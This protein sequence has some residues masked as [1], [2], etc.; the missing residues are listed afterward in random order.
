MAASMLQFDFMLNLCTGYIQ[1]TWMDKD[2]WLTIAN[3]ADKLSLTDLKRTAKTLALWYFSEVRK[4]EQFLCLSFEEIIDYLNDDTLRTVEGEFEV[5]EAGVTWIEHSPDDR[6]F[7]SIP[8]LK[9]VR[10]KQVEPFDIRNM[11]H[12]SSVKDTPQAELIVECIL[13]IINGVLNQK[14]ETCN[15][16]LVDDQ[17]SV[18]SGQSSPLTSGVFF[19]QL[20]KKQRTTSK[21]TCFDNQT[22]ET[23]KELVNREGRC[24][25]LV[26]CVVASFPSSLQ[27]R[28]H[29]LSPRQIVGQKN[30][31]PFV[32]QWDGTKLSPFVHLK[33][34]DQGL[35]GPVGYTV[36]TKGKVIL[37]LK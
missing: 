25:P 2:M 15:P 10:F 1:S 13:E 19:K 20:K 31:R 34:I 5:F 6:L 37:L 32:F 29:F 12:F 35:A 27:V 16:P 8:L 26:P 3:L 28:T 23:A 33:K 4:T 7:H 14:C 17:D 9:A 24:L 30:K 22:M 36:V 18:D 11:L 21:C